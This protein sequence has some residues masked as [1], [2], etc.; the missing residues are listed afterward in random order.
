MTRMTLLELPSLLWAQYVEYL[1]DYK[2]GSWVDASASTFRLAAVFIIAPLALLVML[3]SLFTSCRSS[4]KP[5]DTNSSSLLILSSTFVVWSRCVLNDP[6]GSGT[7]HFVPL[8]CGPIV[9]RDIVYYRANAWSYRRHEGFYE[10][11]RVP[12]PC[13]FGRRIR[14]ETSNDH[15]PIG[16]R[17]GEYARQPGLSGQYGKRPTLEGDWRETTT[18]DRPFEP[19][20]FSSPSVLL[21]EFVV[22]G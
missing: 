22:R 15:R 2:P 6:W 10:R 4:R 13:S 14:R 18:R 21:F 12:A 11:S 3:A 1:W 5:Y 16:V 19:S 17:N 9:G 8:T 20:A 7:V